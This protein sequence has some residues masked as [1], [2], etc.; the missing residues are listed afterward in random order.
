M[1]L[2]PRPHH[3]IQAK[4]WNN[5]SLGTIQVGT[6]DRSCPLRFE[7]EVVHSDVSEKEAAALMRRLNVGALPVAS[8]NAGKGSKL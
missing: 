5:L 4:T 7:V 6:D 8:I 3:R 1:K 2:G